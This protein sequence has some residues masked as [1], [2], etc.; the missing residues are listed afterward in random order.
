MEIIS[1]V[2]FFVGLTLALSLVS[3]LGLDFS[4]YYD[5]EGHIDDINMVTSSSDQI[6]FHDNGSIDCSQYNGLTIAEANMN[7]PCRIRLTTEEETIG[8]S[9]LSD[10]SLGEGLFGT[11]IK[12]SRFL[13]AIFKDMLQPGYILERL[14]QMTNRPSHTDI[15]IYD[16]VTGGHKGETRVR[17]LIGAFSTFMYLMYA[18]AMIQII[19]GFGFKGGV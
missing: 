18:L 5:Y 6:R 13:I 8:K 15:N 1:I 4:Q 19:R 9:G 16:A 14:M 11:T 7:I 17:T 12:A 10:I 3:Q 2:R